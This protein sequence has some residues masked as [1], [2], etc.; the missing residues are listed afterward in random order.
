[1][2]APSLPVHLEASRRHI[3][4]SRC[5]PAG[6]KILTMLLT[7]QKKS[8]RSGRTCSRRIKYLQHSHSLARSPSEKSPC[9]KPHPGQLS[10]PGS[11]SSQCPSQSLHEVRHP[12]LIICQRPL[13]WSREVQ[14]RADP[15]SQTGNC[16]DHTLDHAGNSVDQPLD[17]ILAPLK[18]L[19]RQPSD[20]PDSGRKSIGDH[21]IQPEKGRADPRNHPL[22]GGHRR[23]TQCGC[24]IHRRGIDGV[25]D[26]RRRLLHSGPDPGGGIFDIVPDIC[27]IR[28]QL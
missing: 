18:R 9:P 10:P 24:D 2:P 11:G 1:M 12:S 7:P 16:V 25:P 22:E 13:I 14:E 21:R 23:F 15:V 8:Q 27:R 26:R 17:E 20:K 28:S 4:G 3:P 19:P 5:S 6:R